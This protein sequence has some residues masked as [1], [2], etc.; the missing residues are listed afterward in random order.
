M[1]N[2]QCSHAPLHA[3]SSQNPLPV[4]LKIYIYIYT[5]TLVSTSYVLDGRCVGNLCL[6]MHP[7]GVTKAN[8]D[9]HHES[10]QIEE[11]LLQ[12][13]PTNTFKM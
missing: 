7:V 13:G 9:S 4:S 5:H 1:G 8:D 3:F 10:I 2:T 11:V 6:V 12:S